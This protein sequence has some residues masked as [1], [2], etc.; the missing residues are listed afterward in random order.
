MDQ[1]S[2]ATNRERKLAGAHPVALTVR[3]R[4]PHKKKQTDP[5]DLN[6]SSGNVKTRR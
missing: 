6:G 2:N 4:A 1:V 5:E 3:T